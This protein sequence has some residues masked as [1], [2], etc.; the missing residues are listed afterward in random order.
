M[1]VSSIDAR[2]QDVRNEI[3]HSVWLLNKRH[4][5]FVAAAVTN[6]IDLLRRA[7]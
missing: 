3:C 6:Q 1:F 2:V 5:A 4:A 7:T